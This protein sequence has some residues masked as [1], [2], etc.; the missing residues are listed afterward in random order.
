MALVNTLWLYL[1][2]NILIIKSVAFWIC[3]RGG[4][5]KRRVSPASWGR[6]GREE[7]REL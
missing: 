2:D 5:Q 6:L 7:L 1:E 3:L 4:S